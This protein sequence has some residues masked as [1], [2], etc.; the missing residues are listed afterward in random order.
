VERAFSSLC[1]IFGLLFGS[2]LVSSLSAAMVQFEMLRNGRVQKMSM[3]RRFLRDNEVDLEVSYLVQRQI[4]ERLRGHE[5]LSDKDVP[6]LGLLSS[7]LL[8]LLRQELFRPR[9]VSHPLFR[10]WASMDVQ[11][12]RRLC[13]HLEFAYLRSG[14]DL[15]APGP[16]RPCAYLLL[17]GS[18]TYFQEPDTSPVT[19]ATSE[20]VKADTWLCEAALW[21]VWSHVGTA[22]CSGP[23]GDSC[24]LLVVSLAAVNEVIRVRHALRDI[25]IAYA[26]Q[27]YKRVLAARP[28]KTR[29]PTDVSVPFTDYEDIVA[30]MSASMQEHIGRDALHQLETRFHWRTHSGAFQ[31]LRQEVSDGRS[32]LMVDGVGE[33]MRVVAVLALRIQN[34]EGHIFVQLGKYDHQLG[35]VT[36]ALL[37]PG[38]KQER[39][40]T[41]NEAAQRILETRLSC[42]KDAV[43]FEEVERKVE[44]KNSKGI[45]VRTKYLRTV[46]SA[47]LVVDVD[48]PC[49]GVSSDE[50]GNGSSR[51]STAS[52]ET[53]RRVE[54]IYLMH[55]DRSRKSMGLYAWLTQEEFARVSEGHHEDARALQSLDKL[56]LSTLAD[57][58]EN[59]TLGD[60]KV[61]KNDEQEASFVS[62]STFNPQE[63]YWTDNV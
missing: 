27:Y 59:K 41:S 9:I 58:C 49:L 4:K 51:S 37:L 33:V 44:W 25:I 5:K 1:L 46:C 55:L 48:L 13:F 8:I 3:V 11:L 28:P 60:F 31:N 57:F 30:A 21:I 19:H 32:V 54:T 35:K 53:K 22:V 43:E 52:D 23:A 38:G 40:E 61:N 50:C 42:M 26:T 6:A 17:S 62:T 36:P 39:G 14:D 56:D 45:G 12:M 34:N 47:K 18:M 63:V 10:L 20:S 2:T 7:S 16:A 15:C 29:F 24:R